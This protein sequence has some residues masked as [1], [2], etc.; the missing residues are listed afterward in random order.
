MSDLS[1]QTNSVPE[2]TSLEQLIGLAP[3]LGGWG[4]I[5]EVERRNRILVTL[6]AYAYEIESNPLV[7]D[8]DFD[9]LCLKVNPN[10]PTGNEVLDTFF[11]EEFSPHT[12]QWIH[13]HPYLDKVAIH[14]RRVLPFYKEASNGE[15][16]SL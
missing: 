4:S 8:A 10:E 1:A 15:E 2:L 11:R 3:S 9:E 16:S 7:S 14:Y 13:A 5:T 6:Y 12:G